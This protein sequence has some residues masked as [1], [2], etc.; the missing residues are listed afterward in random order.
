MTVKKILVVDDERELRDIICEILV[1]EGFEVRGAADGVEALKVTRDYHP[2]LILTD[3]IMPQCD[4]LTLFKEVL[5][6]Y[7]P[8]IPFIFIS[9]YVGTVE[10]DEIKNNKN[11]VSIFNK[12]VDIDKVLEKIKSVKLFLPNQ[13]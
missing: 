8:P 6:L 5:R 2:D 11:F 13:Y 4:G 1:F 9:G 12:P 10:I 7:D 3:I